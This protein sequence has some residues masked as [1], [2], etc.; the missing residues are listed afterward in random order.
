[1]VALA[2]DPVIRYSNVDCIWP[3]INAE[4]TVP[5]RLSTPPNTTTMKVS[6]M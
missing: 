1:M 5:S 6:T 2:I 3:M 4:A